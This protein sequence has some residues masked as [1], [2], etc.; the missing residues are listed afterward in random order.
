[1]VRPDEY[2]RARVPFD[3][4][5]R[6]SLSHIATFA[7]VAYVLLTRTSRKHGNARVRVSVC[8]D[9]QE[10][11]YVRMPIHECLASQINLTPPLAQHE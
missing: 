5:T 4:D 8:M 7:Y 10:K 2:T 11:W 9:I 3:L 6:N 1:M